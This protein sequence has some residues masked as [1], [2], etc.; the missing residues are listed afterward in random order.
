AGDSALIFGQ[1]QNQAGAFS[2]TFTATGGCDSTH[3]I[4]LDVLPAL[5]TSESRSICAGDSALIFG[6][7]QNQAGAFSQTLTATQAIRP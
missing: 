4:A 1:W 5:Q 3:T 2:Q 7:W 6:Q